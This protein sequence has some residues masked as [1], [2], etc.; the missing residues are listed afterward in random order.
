MAKL[1]TI[2][3]PTF[4]RAEHLRVLLRTLAQE[5]R[6]LEDEVDVIVS[7]NAATDATPEVTAEF[8]RDWPAAR[9]LR[10]EANIG[11]EKNFCECVERCDSRYFWIIG[12]DDVP[13]RGA[14]RLLLALLREQAPDLLFL[15]T[16]WVPR[17]DGSDQIGPIDRLPFEVLSREDFA[18]R[19]HIHLTFISGVIVRF[20]GL[21]ER[22]AA[23]AMRRY[24]GTSF[25]QLAWVLAQL[26]EGR[27]FIHVRERC[28]LATEGN[29]GGY[30]ALTVFGA[31]FPRIVGE[32][33]QPHPQA[34][35]RIVTRHLACYLPSLLWHVRFTHAPG[36]FTREDAWPAIRAQIGHHPLYWLYV[37]PVGRGPRWLAWL[38]YAV[39][40]VLARML[41]RLDRRAGAAALQVLEPA[42][43]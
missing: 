6:G 10:Q 5:L 4:N 30:A 7:D 12:D 37:L 3:V 43:P 9:L 22:A 24:V 27:R 2:A 20:D 31:N 33:L 25:P 8:L 23:G 18:R 41:A 19:V 14:V 34:A 28:M 1:L 15:D 13:R 21:H 38:V 35:Q 40:R 26:D 17:I 16:A 32:M 11:P 42:R 39:S 36:R 29:T